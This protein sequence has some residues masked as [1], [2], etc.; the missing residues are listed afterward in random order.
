MKLVCSDKYLKSF[1]YFN[2]YLLLFF[3]KT[4]FIIVC[5]SFISK[6]QVG[7]INKKNCSDQIFVSFQLYVCMECLLKEAWQVCVHANFCYFVNNFL[8]LNDFYPKNQSAIVLYVI[9]CFEIENNRSRNILFKKIINNI[10]F[11]FYFFIVA[12]N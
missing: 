10:S 2:A 8:Y 9:F 7:L 5:I 11:S 12:F 1:C 6:K 3:K 4:Q